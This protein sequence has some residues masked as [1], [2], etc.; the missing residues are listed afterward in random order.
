MVGIALTT[1][2]LVVRSRPLRL[3]DRMTR[4]PRA[5]SRLQARCI[6]SKQ[7]LLS[8]SRSGTVNCRRKIP[9]PPIEWGFEF[10][11]LIFVNHVSDRIRGIHQCRSNIHTS[12][13]IG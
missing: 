9:I 8:S 5:A 1:L 11:R 6:T 4:N 7:A 12:L 2:L 13:T 3:G 10:K